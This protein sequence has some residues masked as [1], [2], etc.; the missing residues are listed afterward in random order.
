MPR[1]IG[2]SGPVA[3][4]TFTIVSD[5]TTLGRETGNDIVIEAQWVSRTHC[6]IRKLETGLQ[7]VDRES[8]NGTVVN[9]V[10]IKERLLRGG[11]RITLGGASFLFVDDESDEAEP[12]PEPRPEI[13]LEDVPL[14]SRKTVELRAA[15]AIY[16]APQRLPVRGPGDEETRKALSATLSLI[17]LVG[18]GDVDTLPDRIL[19]S[20]FDLVG[21]ERGAI[22]MGP[23]LAELD[24]VTV[25]TASGPGPGPGPEGG[26]RSA[27]AVS[28][29]VLGKVLSENTAILSNRVA[30]ELKGKSL[31]AAGVSALVCLPLIVEGRTVGAIYLDRTGLGSGFSEDLLELLMGLASVA[32]G[33][34]E[35]ARQLGRLRVIERG[36]KEEFALVH[37]MVGE[38][39]RLEEAQRIIA[40]A[41]KTDA[42]VLI[43]GESGT[44]KELA[45]RAIHFN[46][47]RR[48]GP[49]V[50]V[51]CTGLN[52]NLLSS[53]LFGHERGAFTGAIQQKKG[54]L[55]VANGGT[56]FLDEIGELPLPLQSRLLR[57][58]QD[59]EF[60]RVGGT[61]LIRADIRL[62][63]ATNRNLAEEVKKGS[64]REDLFHRLNVVRLSLPPLRERPEDIELLA[65]YFAAE[66]GKRVKRRVAGVSSEALAI[67]KRYEWPGNVRELGNAIERAVV[68][69][70]TDLILP[71]DLPESMVESRGAAPAASS[72]H[73]AVA[74]KKKELILDSIRTSKGS[75]TEAA[76]LLGLHPNYLHRLIRNLDLRDRVQS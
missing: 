58:L 19:G 27:F 67:L 66:H 43:E 55:E 38:S 11:D 31:V 5:R 51:D 40:R 35:R 13:E 33:G 57:V 69:G 73:E 49:L 61:H 56:V 28:R 4:E 63:A 15:D 21:A 71:E 23:S 36:M 22:L 10:P 68:L 62:V 48:D 70:T 7:I 52:E 1:L 12:V 72:Y 2:L 65:R 50:K 9:D 53:E 39:A 74:E 3:G 42:T 16:L 41:A 76:K 47:E 14:P 8:H 37:E 54:K 59:R 45:A 34:L 26:R 17:R 75:I 64:F 60:E 32:A 29:T 6:E 30:D 24:P 18:E 46:S 20:F 44:G 25:R